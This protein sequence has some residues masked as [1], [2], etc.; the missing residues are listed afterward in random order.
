MKV[1]CK[2]VPKLVTKEGADG[3]LFRLVAIVTGLKNT[4]KVND[5][6]KI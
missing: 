1:S 3:T 5:W 4:F 6:F 2:P